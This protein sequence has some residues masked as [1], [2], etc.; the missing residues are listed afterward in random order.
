MRCNKK[1]LR[2]IHAQWDERKR[3]EDR[4]ANFTVS[5]ALVARRRPPVCV[6]VCVYLSALAHARGEPSAPALLERT[7][8][9]LRPLF[10]DVRATSGTTAH[11][12]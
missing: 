2:V 6:F 9:L 11:R 12:Y 5:F 1:T 7:V 10:R 3:E 4:S 8:W